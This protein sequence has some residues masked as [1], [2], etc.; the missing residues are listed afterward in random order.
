[1][2]FPSRRAFFF[3]CFS[4][5]LHY[6]RILNMY[7]GDKSC[8]PLGEQKP[9]MCVNED[10]RALIY[11]GLVPLT[12]RCLVFLCMEAEEVVRGPLQDVLKWPC[13]E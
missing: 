8:S 13:A 6:E 11:M 10:R 1:M 9:F 5:H 4:D 7:D 2:Q 3:F 12:P